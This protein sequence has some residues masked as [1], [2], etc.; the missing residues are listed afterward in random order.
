MPLVVPSVGEEN[1]LSMAL[2]ANFVHVTLFS[3]ILKLLAYSTL[4][5][6]ATCKETNLEVIY[7]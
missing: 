3:K 7:I 4:K 5:S 2:C 6:I 1:L